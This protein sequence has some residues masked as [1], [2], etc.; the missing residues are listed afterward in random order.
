MVVQLMDYSSQKSV[1]QIDKHVRVN[2]NLA[3]WYYMNMKH[4]KH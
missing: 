2:H 1:I 4:Y 3:K